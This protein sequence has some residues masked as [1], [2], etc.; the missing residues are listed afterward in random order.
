MAGA[1]LSTFADALKI[2]YL[3]NI[4]EQVNNFNYF[5]A[6]LSKKAEMID[7]DGSNFSITHHYGRNS[8]VS[9]G[10][11]S[12]SLP[13]A[14]AQGYKKSTGQVSY[15]HGRL[16]VTNAMINAAKRNETSYIRA[17][18]SEVKGL[19]SDIKNFKN[20]V[21]FMD[22]TGVLATT[23]AATS[24]NIV[25]VNRVKYFFVGQQV[26]ILDST[27]GTQKAIARNITAIDRKNATITID[28]AA[29]TTL[30]TDI[31]VSSTTA[32]NSYG[33]E[34]LGL[35]AVISDTITLQGLA[36]ATYTWWKANVFG[37]GGTNRAI[38]DALLR[39]AIDETSVVSGEETDFLVSSYGTR[40]AYEAVL[41]TL[42]RFTNP[43][44][45]D[46]G[47]KALEFDGK[48]FLVDRYMHSNRVWGGGFDD[49][50]LYYT[51][52][53]QFM[54]EDGSMFNRVPN[55]P[56]YEA[57]AFCYETMVCHQRNAFWALNDITEA[58]G[59]T[60]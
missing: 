16:Q 11:E 49:L 13:T 27:G 60:V 50:G 26:D 3:P 34:P 18:E 57:T 8:G 4:K 28:G 47:Y 36:P 21:M 19:T 32:G 54:E 33:I 5:A 55:T 2:D 46:G 22:G 56:A 23:A 31:V 29:V 17:L 53:L 24:V 7:G 43:M 25:P 14:G 58:S 10:T 44:E 12:G 30:A 38:S 35:A 40:A 41:T 6:Q 37:N 52:D 9:A 48:P 59:F 45:L 42:K 15:I 20:R 51:A 1:S 39:L